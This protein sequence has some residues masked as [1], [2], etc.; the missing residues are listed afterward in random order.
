LPVVGFTVVKAIGF[1]LQRRDGRRRQSFGLR[2][3][4]SA[5]HQMLAIVATTPTTAATGLTTLWCDPS[6]IP[7]DLT[8]FARAFVRLGPLTREVPNAQLGRGRRRA[9]RERIHRD[10]TRRQP[11]GPPDWLYR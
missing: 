11:V 7:H 1:S 6:A 5:N 3:G 2:R 8:A 9:Y 10:E 4:R